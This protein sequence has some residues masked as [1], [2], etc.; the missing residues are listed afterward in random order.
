VLEPAVARERHAGLRGF[1]VL[2]GLAVL[3]LALALWL[4]GS[5]AWRH[6]LRSLASL[7]NAGALA[8]L[9][10]SAQVVAGV[11]AVLITVVAI[12]VELAANRYTHRITELFVRDRVNVAVLA[13]FVLT[14]VL[15]VWLA[16]ALSGRVGGAPPLPR[17]GFMLVMGMMTACVL[18]LLPYF[19]YVFHFLSPHE[20]IRRIRSEAL[21]RVGRAREGNVPEAKRAV[22][23]VVEELEDI[24]R[25]A[26]QHS[27]RGIAMA[28][29]VALFDLLADVTQLRPNLPEDWFLIDEAI[30]HDADFVSMS[31]PAL[32][33]LSRE[34][35]W[36][37][38]KI[39]RQCLALF[40]DAVTGARDVANMIAIHTRRVA[41]NYAATYPALL[42][43]CQRAF[44][45]YLRTAINA[46][47][48]RTAYYVLHQYR[49]LGE[50][51]L[52]KGL[53]SDALEA[54]DRIRFYGRLA[55]ANQL[56]FLLEVAAYDLAHMVEA[57][58]K[59]AV[60]DALLDVLLGIDQPG[61]EHLPGV[62]RAQIQLGTFFLARGEEAPA[63][64][65]A[66]VLATED[67]GLL[68]AARQELEREIS[69]QYWEITDRGSNFAYL[70]PERRARLGELF[71]LIGQGVQAEG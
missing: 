28:A 66:A 16:V 24:A 51:L 41:E 15:C 59:P 49:L 46:R 39:L 53:E 35:A 5:D 10:G 45:S 60:R 11:L 6:P 12:V 31:P 40:G 1:A 52:A 20:V 38:A 54:A 19:A 34:G 25:S 70:P 36:F 8:L 18:M 63:R 68:R 69:P 13:F 30:A 37:E 47:D 62:R 50:D 48:R 7:D 58:D 32:E 27:D 43:Q 67:R 44:H 2:L 42:T 56:P 3:L 29:V 9:A 26:M 4:E 23:A 17:G 57:A 64:R 71:T 14:T 65:I 55:G 22:I 61:A 21:E 33:E